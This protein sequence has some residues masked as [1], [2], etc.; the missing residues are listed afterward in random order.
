M[1]WPR[2]RHAVRDLDVG[3]LRLWDEK[4]AM[5]GDVAAVLFH[6]SDL[7]APVCYAMTCDAMP[8]PQFHGV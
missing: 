5:E 7:G 2:Q 8:L 1:H 3:S 4:S 6:G